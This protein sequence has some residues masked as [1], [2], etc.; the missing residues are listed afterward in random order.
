M[1]HP[2]RIVSLVP[3]QTELLYDLALEKEVIGITKFCIHPEL[4]HRNKTRIGGT[5][6]IHPEIIRGLQPTLILANKE[7]NV[8]EQVEPLRELCPVYV[9]DIS[10]LSG[11]LEMIRHVGELTGRETRAAALIATIQNGFDRLGGNNAPIPCAY[12]IWKD[13]WM[14][15]G[16]DTFINDMLE[17]AGFVNVFRDRLRYPIIDRDILAASGC[18]QILLSSEP[19]PFQEKHIREFRAFLPG[20]RV[21]LVDG[22]MFSWYGSRLQYA[23]AYFQ[24]LKKLLI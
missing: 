5:K 17:R 20:V 14:V 4:W 23:P 6:N 16:G 10:D 9:S 13:P 22:E 2:Y 15:A 7:E 18:R 3:S 1:T 8:K 19:Y 11:A 24:D 21:C 12:F